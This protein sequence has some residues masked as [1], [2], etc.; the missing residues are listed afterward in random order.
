MT[1]SRGFPASLESEGEPQD[2]KREGE[3]CG[4]RHPEEGRDE[5]GRRHLCSCARFRRA[6]H[7]P[8]R[9]GV[10]QLPSSLSS[11][12][13]GTPPVVFGRQTADD[14]EQLPVP[15]GQRRF[16]PLPLRYPERCLP[17]H[18]GRFLRLREPL[19]DLRHP[20]S[21][22]QDRIG[23]D[24]DRVDPLL[25]RKSANSAKA[26]GAGPPSIT[27]LLPAGPRPG[28]PPRPPQG[29][30]DS[31][32]PRPVSSGPVRRRAGSRWGC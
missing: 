15:R 25:H 31:S 23:F 10:R 5:R 4:R 2:G 18:R 29:R 12:G 9:Q 3:Q 13:G 17:R 27:P 11:H 30:P 26:L 21:D 28:R 20:E 32:A 14:A 22:L 19:L 7:R 16:Y 6:V 24:R 8:R 1:V